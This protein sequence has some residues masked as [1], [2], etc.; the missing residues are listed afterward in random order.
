[1]GMFVGDEEQDDVTCLEEYIDETY[2]DSVGGQHDCGIGWNPNGVWC[3]ECSNS[4]CENCVH[5]YATE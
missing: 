4:T 1:M 5:R 2:I 3:G